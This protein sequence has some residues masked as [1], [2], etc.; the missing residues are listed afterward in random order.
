VFT[1]D[2][3][4]ITLVVGDGCERNGCKAQEAEVDVHGVFSMARILSIQ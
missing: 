1:S 3:T 2:K 4:Y